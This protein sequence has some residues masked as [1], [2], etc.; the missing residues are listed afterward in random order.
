MPGIFIATTPNVASTCGTPVVDLTNTGTGGNVAISN[1]TVP[2]N[3]DYSITKLWDLTADLRVQSFR[4]S[5]TTKTGATIGAWRSVGSNA[6]VGVGYHAGG[7]HSDLRDLDTP[8]T[9]AF[10]NLIA[11]F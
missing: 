11:T 6:K 9:G 8:E 1:A 2:I 7:V 3:T 5:G 4:E 10:I